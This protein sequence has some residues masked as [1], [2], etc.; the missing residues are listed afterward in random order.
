MKKGDQRIIHFSGANDPA[1]LQYVLDTIKDEKVDAAILTGVM[2]ASDRNPMYRRLSNMG[3]SGLFSALEREW[4]VIDHYQDK[5]K[6]KGYDPSS[7]TDWERTELERTRLNIDQY[8]RELIGDAERIIRNGYKTVARDLS[9]IVDKVPIVGILGPHDFTPAYDE[10]REPVALTD[11]RNEEGFTLRGKSGNE[12]SIKGTLNL[13]PS[14]IDQTL[15]RLRMSIDKYMLNRCSGV[16]EEEFEEFANKA[17]DL[18]ET[19][20]VIQCQEQVRDLREGERLRLGH[21]E[22]IDILL[23]NSKPG[24]EGPL[25]HEYSQGAKIV[26][27]GGDAHGNLNG[28]P[29]ADVLKGAWEDSEYK[30]GVRPQEIELPMDFLTNKFDQLRIDP[31]TEN[32]ML[33]DFDKEGKVI[34]VRALPL[35]RN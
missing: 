26:L 32:L 6:K 14:Q 24:Y 5:I 20:E 11:D 8:K 13:H 15:S 12:L 28:W 9:P 17:K 35:Y 10:L 16:T 34:G 30:G 3:T 18:K 25:V 33:Y 22:G 1:K 29:L 27:Q 23:T 4:Q 2:E 31:G 19:Q 21:P 7:L